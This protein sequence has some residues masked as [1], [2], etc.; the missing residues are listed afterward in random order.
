MAQDAA[1][2]I[3][4]LARA[5]GEAAGLPAEAVKVGPGP[6]SFSRYVPSIGRARREHGL[7]VLLPLRV[8]LERTLRAI[9]DAGNQ[10]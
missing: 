1:V 10:R 2:T 7:E 5:V 6:S 4:E 3:A 8:S 9:R